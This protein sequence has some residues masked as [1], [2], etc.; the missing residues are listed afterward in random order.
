MNDLTHLMHRSFQK[1]QIVFNAVIFRLFAFK[2][3]GPTEPF[4]HKVENTVHG[5]NIEL[6]GMKWWIQVP[7]T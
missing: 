2:I 3:A 5:M 7:D 4:Y 1:L 6:A